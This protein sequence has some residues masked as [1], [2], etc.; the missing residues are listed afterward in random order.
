MGIVL[1]VFMTADAPC[2]INS[3]RIRKPRKARKARRKMAKKT[4]KE[5]IIRIHRGLVEVVSKP[6]SLRVLLRDYDIANEYKSEEEVEKYC[7]ERDE[8][9]QYVETEI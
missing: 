4:S 6:K 3:R 5:V 1:S 2:K 9:G 7:P 8:L